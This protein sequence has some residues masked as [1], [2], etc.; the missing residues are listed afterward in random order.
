MIADGRGGYAMASIHQ[1]LTRKYHGLLVA[2][3]E[4]VEGR[5]VLLAKLEATVQVDGLAYEL[6]TNDYVEAVH[7]QGYRLLESFAAAPI[8]TWRWRV[9]SALIEQTLCMPPGA[10]T[11]FVRYRLIEAGAPAPIS[12]RPL[13][14]SRR[15]E[16]LT[17]YRNMGPPTTEEG[18]Q[19][20]AIHWPGQ[21]PDLHLSHNG[22][23]RNRPDWY[24]R[25][26]LTTDAQRGE[27]HSQDLF[28]PGVIKGTLTPGDPTG[29]VVA[30]S[31]DAVAWQRAGDAFERAAAR[32]LSP[33]IPE[34]SQFNDPLLESLSRAAEAFV[35]RGSDN[36]PTI[37][38]GYPWFGQWGRDAMISLPGLCLVTGRFDDARAV[39]R[40]FAGQ[41]DGG[42]IP[43]RCGSAGRQP[44]YN[45]ADAS[46]WFVH[47][48]DRYLAYA[49]DASSM[50]DE[51][52]NAIS[53]I[54]EAYERGTRFG[55]RLDSDGLLSCGQA[56]CA[57][58]W[59]DAIVDG[60]PVTPR[61]G[62]PVE[63]NALWYNALMIGGVLAEQSGRREA[64]R[65]WKGLAEASC[66]AFNRKFW[67]A[68]AQCLFDV[69][70]DGGTPDR[71]DGT[72]R[73]NQL[74]SMSLTY[75][76][77]DRARFSSVLSVCRDQ[78]LTPMGL[79]TLSPG[80]PRFQGRYAGNVE[81]RDSA[82]HQGTVWPW[83]FG[84]FM[85][86]FVR[87]EGGGAASRKTARSVLDALLSHLREAGL[88]S[89]SE[90]ADGDAPHLSGGCP[91]QAW[92][93]AEPLRALCEDVYEL[94][95]RRPSGARSG[96]PA[97]RLESPAAT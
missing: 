43:N 15:I 36:E 5:F 38:A 58:T 56:G 25:F 91:W 49:G 77:L 82:Y 40:T 17:H 9:G 45:S 37:V 2:A 74:F 23:F 30:A 4:P 46:L 86:A 52:L 73:P 8:P 62:K 83:L 63:I 14:T 65:H 57:V 54:L 61:I 80:D 31:T 59:M 13:C 68:S 97:R 27:D 10:N 69:V 75:P 19:R 64:A 78:L 44:A 50:D 29:F 71:M 67:N 88:G 53:T 39:L 90:V 66:G 42:M 95:P 81:S 7:P 87:A 26:V 96:A 20:F 21:R 12:I 72:I 84:P 32:P 34:T 55:I 18:V 94:E 1:G 22:R 24:Y 35:V 76:V 85:T 93:V 70:D 51:L 48:V 11:T 47:A 89:V 16:S 6:G 41:I 79:R 92:S 28:M 3:I 60:I 33:S